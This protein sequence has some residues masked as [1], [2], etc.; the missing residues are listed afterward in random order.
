MAESER[1]LSEKPP[2]AE[3]SPSA[4]RQGFEQPAASPA[5]KVP[6]K[7]AEVPV[8]PATTAPAPATGTGLAQKTETQRRI[9]SVMEDGLGE[10]YKNMP[11]EAKKKFREEGEKAAAEI[12]TLLYKVK[13]HSKK[14]FKLVFAWLRIIPGVNKY[15]LEQEA[16]L[17]TDEIIKLKDDMEKARSGQK[18]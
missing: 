8:V 14:I 4:D 11:P 3:A 17:K 2:A 15:F 1:P 9:E 7:A 10:V 12:E 6:S 13:V 5:E 18:I 16:K